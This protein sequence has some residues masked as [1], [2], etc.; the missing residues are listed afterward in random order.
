MN[1]EAVF[2]K[3]Q[4]VFDDVFPDPVPLTPELTPKDV[5]AWDSMLHISLV[6][7][8]EQAFAIRFKLGEVESTGNVGNLV[9]LIR[10][11]VSE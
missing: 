7:A 10:R 9:E 6:V 11:K 3:L 1:T 4:M 5:P 8:M 2:A